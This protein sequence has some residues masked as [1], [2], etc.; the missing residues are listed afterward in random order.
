MTTKHVPGL[1]A[2]ATL[3][4]LVTVVAGGCTAATP[5]RCSRVELGSGSPEAGLRVRVDGDESLRLDDADDRLVVAFTVVGDAISPLFLVHHQ[6]GRETGRWE[7]KP[8]KPSGVSARCAMA[9][10]GT[11]STC[12]ATFADGPVALGGEWT[13]EQGANRILEVGMS[14]RLCR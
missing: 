3:L 8:G 9:L 11:G 4:A 13:I 1:P 2:A 6:E 7:L 14:A 10:P 12:S 5:Q